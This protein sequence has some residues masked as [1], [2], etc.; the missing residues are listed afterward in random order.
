MTHTTAKHYFI[1]NSPIS[2]GRFTY[3]DT[4]FN[5]KTWHEGASLTIG[6]FCS[7]SS[8]LTIFLGGNHRIDW[9]TTYPFGHIFCNDLNVGNIPGH[10]STNGDVVIGSD[11][12][13][14]DGVTIMS[15]ITIGDGAVIAANSHVVKNVM[16]Y[17]II[18]GNPARM[19]KK[20]FT[21]DIIDKLLILKWWELS[22]QDITTI[23]KVLC[24]E[25][26]IEILD[27]LIVKY[28]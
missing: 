6:S 16:P 22:I 24:S 12:W 19:I 3:G 26:T 17:E 13:I 28:R 27:E 15:G 10:P 20:R 1:E 7:L 8:N 18:G 14:G 11:V 9:I 23:S 4:L 25:P 5:V 21:D 2:I